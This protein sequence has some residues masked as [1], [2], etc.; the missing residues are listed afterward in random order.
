MFNSIDSNSTVEYLD[1]SSI[2]MNLRPSLDLDRLVG[3]KDEY[4][5]MLAF[6]IK[7]KLTVQSIFK[8]FELF[9]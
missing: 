3:T 4:L 6:Q 9:H 2:N 1:E 8:T 5:S 7:D